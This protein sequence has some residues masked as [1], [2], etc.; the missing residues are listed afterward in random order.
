MWFN[1]VFVGLILSGDGTV[2]FYGDDG[3]A[4]FQSGLIARLDN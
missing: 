2:T 4:T 1:G 3:G